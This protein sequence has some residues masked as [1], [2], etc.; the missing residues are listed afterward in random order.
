MSRES[1]FRSYFVC[2]FFARRPHQIPRVCHMRCRNLGKKE[3][4]GLFQ[5]NQPCMI[6]GI[7]I[8]LRLLLLQHF[9]DLWDAGIVNHWTDSVENLKLLFPLF[10]VTFFFY[11]LIK[12]CWRHHT[13]LLIFMGQLHPWLACSRL[14]DSRVR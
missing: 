8:K 10:I 1:N 4:I 5:S 11:F 14:R 7:G 2:L 3:H 9:R 12:V 13:L 6:T